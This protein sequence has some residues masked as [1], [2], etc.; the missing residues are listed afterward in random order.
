VVERMDEMAAA[1]VWGNGSGQ[2]KPDDDQIA[3]MIAPAWK[4]KVA[5]FRGSGHVYVKG[6]WQ[7]R[8]PQE[9][10]QWTRVVLRRLREYGVS[11]SARR[12]E[13]V[14]KLVQYDL[15]VAERIL[16]EAERH[17]AHYINFR[18]GLLN[19][20]TG[21]L[22]EHRR[23]LYFISQLDYDYDPDA[24]CPSF[25]QFLRT[26]LTD[27]SGLEPD[28]ETIQLV[29]E[30]MGYSL[31][32]RTDLQASFWLTGAT[33]AGKSTLIKALMLVAGDMAGALDLNQLGTN[34]YQLA[35]LVGKR[36][37]T[38][39]E[40]DTAVLPDGLFKALT[41]GGDAM[42]A[43]VKYESPFTFVP[44]AKL[45]WAMNDAPRTKDRSG[46]L[47]R[48]LRPIVFNR[49]IP[50]E[51]RDYELDAK[52]EQE[53]AGICAWALVGLKRLQRRGTFTMPKQSALWLE[54]YERRNDHPRLFRD[55]NMV[56]AAGHWV[57]AMELYNR[58]DTWCRSMGI[59]A[60]GYPS[61]AAEWKRLGFHYRQVSA[62]SQYGG[63]RFKE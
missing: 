54:E 2:H 60:L 49:T 4:D 23:D 10:L 62:G 56:A 29:Q 47:I 14:L 50:P 58:Y 53:R 40:S 39:T 9:F 51:E 26:S 1:A 57:G 25:R 33:G 13:S 5:F 28:W 48:R 27:A 3:L 18:N 46:A 20:E 43:E 6:Y 7:R 61:M 21:K 38:C 44:V 37:V 12:I 63:W 45:W 19:L 11:V 22:E 34:R 16:L 31:T 59:R 42:Q 35:T 24:D 52:L 36:L 55:E 17:Q 15:H 8:D 41:G 32:S 30:A